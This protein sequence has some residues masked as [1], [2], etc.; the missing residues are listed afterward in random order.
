MGGLLD[1]FR[2]EN[3]RVPGAPGDIYVCP[4]EAHE[5]DEQA[6][7]HTVIFAPIE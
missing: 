3:L 1:E 7:M 5:N 6:K 2:A 4:P